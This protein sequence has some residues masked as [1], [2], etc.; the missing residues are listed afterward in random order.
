MP[1]M[2]ASLW[3]YSTGSVLPSSW[4]AILGDM[5]M[6]DQ[7]GCNSL[8][9]DPSNTIYGVSSDQLIGLGHL[10]TMDCPAGDSGQRKCKIIILYVYSQA[11]PVTEALL[12]GYIRWG[13]LPQRQAE[14]ELTIVARHSKA[15]A[16]C[17][18]ET[19]NVVCV[20]GTQTPNTP[21]SHY[22]FTMTAKC[23]CSSIWKYMKKIW[24]TNVA[25]FEHVTNICIHGLL[26]FWQQNYCI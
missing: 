25:L 23:H 18:R 26:W 20:C 16:P 2:H 8:M 24:L 10:V 7:A 15:S 6:K 21:D 4:Q 17:W 1:T 14:D 5:S 3:L 22:K 9:E 12:L 13:T 19:G 11:A